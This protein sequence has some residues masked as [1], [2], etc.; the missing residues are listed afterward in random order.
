MLNEFVKEENVM[1][2]IMIAALALLTVLAFALPATAA[3]VNN[4]SGTVGFGGAQYDMSNAVYVD[5]TI[6]VPTNAQY[7]GISTVHSGG[8]RMFATTS[9]T[10]VIWWRTVDKGCANPDPIDE[11][12]TSGQFTSPWSS[13]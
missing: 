2:K 1:K 4:A 8:N 13:L 5:Y 11:T 12:W 6:D 3:D 9:E 7:Y 10:S